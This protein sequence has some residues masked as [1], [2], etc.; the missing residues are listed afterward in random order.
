M[1]NQEQPIGIKE[2]AVFTEYSISTLYKLTSKGL[3]PH[4]KLSPK[5][6]IFYKSE[7]SEWIQNNGRF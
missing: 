4:H 2:V 1:H 7:L 3:I 6:L 5:K